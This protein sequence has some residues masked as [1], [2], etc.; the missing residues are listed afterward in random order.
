LREACIPKTRS[1]REA[2]SMQYRLINCNASTV[3]FLDAYQDLSGRGCQLFTLSRQAPI[4][5]NLELFMRFVIPATNESLS[6]SDSGSRDYVTYHTSRDTCDSYSTA[7]ICQGSVV[8]TTNRIN[9][10]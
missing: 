2:L 5:S 4:L 8:P 9:G 7:S 1:N 10:V 3:S 6:E